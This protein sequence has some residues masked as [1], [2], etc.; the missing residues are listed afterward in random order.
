MED[1]IV[2]SGAN[3]IVNSEQKEYLSDIR[4]WYADLK[5]FTP[6]TW[7]SYDEVDEDGPYFC[8]GEDKSLK[9]DFWKYCYA[10]DKS[11]LKATLSNLEEALPGNQELIIRKFIPLKN[12]GNSPSTGMPIS[13]E[14]RRFVFMGE[15]VSTGF[16][17]E[18][19]ANEYGLNSN[20]ELPP[21]NF[22]NNI[23][24][25]IGTKANYYTINT[26][27]MDQGDWIVIELNSGAQAG[28][29]GINSQQHYQKMNSIWNNL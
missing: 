14:F 29:S 15:Q 9:I 26:A 19:F 28:L 16:Y 3:V 8:K 10:E 11:N 2:R 17:W 25:K 18:E 27:L 4:N 5:D 23:I 24:N 22:V 7:N 1:E 20:I 6:K 21:N 12:Y 13:H